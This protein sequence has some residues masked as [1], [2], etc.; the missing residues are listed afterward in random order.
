[1]GAFVEDGGLIVDLGC[2]T[3]TSTRR[4]AAAY[5]EAKEVASPTSP[6]ALVLQCLALNSVMPHPGCRRRSLAILHRCCAAA[7][8]CSESVN[9]SPGSSRVCKD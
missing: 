9:C 8:G 3:G 5:P 6:Y 4:L 7:G 2:G 1:M